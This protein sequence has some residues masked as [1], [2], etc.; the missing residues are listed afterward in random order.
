MIDPPSEVP[1]R[2]LCVDDN[3]D[4]ADTEVELLIAVGCE[5]RACYDGPSAL[6]HAEAFEPDICFVDLHMPGMDGD[7]LAVLL[8]E[9]AT[10]RPIV[11]VA[12]T[13]MNDETSRQRIKRAFDRH[14][15]KP[16]ATQ[17][18]LAVIGE[19]QQACQVAERGPFSPSRHLTRGIP[20][21][22]KCPL[23]A[24]TVFG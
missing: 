1:V 8:R 10:G 7:E 11:L 22:P 6:L 14:L 20:K 12:I 21:S 4:V 2:I 5:A 23:P 17:D 24:G 19:F 9:R 16:A 13:A 3:R 18:L 15:V